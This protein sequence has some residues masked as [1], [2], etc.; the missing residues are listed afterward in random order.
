MQ[1]GNLE[2]ADEAESTLLLSL[3]SPAS[4]WTGDK[5]KGLSGTRDRHIQ[6][7]SRAVGMDSINP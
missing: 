1:R 2:E 4:G 6:V 3:D 5:G 7:Y